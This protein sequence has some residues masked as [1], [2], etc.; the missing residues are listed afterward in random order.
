MRQAIWKEIEVA[1][2]KA[3]RQ[4]AANAHL[5]DVLSKP[6]PPGVDIGYVRTPE[7]EHALAQMRVNMQALR[8]CIGTHAG[9]REAYTAT[10]SS[11]SVDWGTSITSDNF[12]VE[13]SY[14][15]PFIIVWTYGTPPQDVAHALAACLARLPVTQLTD[16][17]VD[18]LYERKLYLTLF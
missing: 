6:I 9:V 15:A 3:Q 2:A 10:V 18:E 7:S 8:D 13:F 1:L 14:W 4:R 5:D 17:E 12:V 16:D 11:I